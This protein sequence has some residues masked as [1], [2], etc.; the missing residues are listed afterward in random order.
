MVGAPNFSLGA[1]GDL[2]GVGQLVN[3]S[4]ETATSVVVE[5]ENFAHRVAT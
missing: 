5:L 2:Y 3:A 4:F 1:E